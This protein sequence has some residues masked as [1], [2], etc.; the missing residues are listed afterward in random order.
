MIKYDTSKVQGWK[1][2]NMHFLRA[3]TSWNNHPD[4][5][6]TSSLV[7]DFESKLNKA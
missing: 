5:V 6:I 4:S 1:L 2:G 7:M 3:V